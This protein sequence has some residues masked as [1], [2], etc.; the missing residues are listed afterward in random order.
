MSYD[1]RLP[2]DDLGETVHPIATNEA[3]I[4]QAFSV[5][6]NYSV[7]SLSSIPNDAA[8]NVAGQLPHH[9]STSKGPGM[10]KAKL[11]LCRLG[12]HPLTDAALCNYTFIKP[13]IYDIS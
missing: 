9:G 6:L 10:D 1:V 8:A 5:A 3:K 2:I 12:R 11:S 4:C 13:R 7:A